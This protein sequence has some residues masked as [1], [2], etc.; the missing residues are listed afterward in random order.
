MRGNR[1]MLTC[2]TLNGYLLILKRVKMIVQNML[3]NSNAMPPMV[4]LKM[5]P[6]RLI[7]LG[8][9]KKAI[10]FPDESLK[11]QPLAHSLHCNGIMC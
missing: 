9:S 10:G 5:D 4:L 8:Y 3:P 6:P 1:L 7:H 11:C 2:L